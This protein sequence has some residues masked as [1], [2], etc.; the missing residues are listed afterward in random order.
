MCDS[1]AVTLCSRQRCAFAGEKPRG[2]KTLAVWDTLRLES[3]QSAGLYACTPWSCGR[4]K[5]L[6]S[7]LQ[8]RA[9][10]LSG[11]L[12]LWLLYGGDWIT[13]SF[14]LTRLWRNNNILNIMEFEE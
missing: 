12:Y 6:P 11:W 14:M 10:R 4:M 9:E 3:A 5:P 7:A 2:F 13:S 1:T 8:G